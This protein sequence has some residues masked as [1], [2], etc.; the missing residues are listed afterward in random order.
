MLFLLEGMHGKFRQTNSECLKEL[1]PGWPSSNSLLHYPK[2]HYYVN[3]SSKARGNQPQKSFAC[4]EAASAD[5]EHVEDKP[6]VSLSELFHG[7]H[8]FR[9]P[10]KDLFTTDLATPKFATSI[11]NMM[12]NETRTAED[13]LRLVKEKLKELGVERKENDHNLTSWRNS[14]TYVEKSGHGSTTTYSGKPPATDNENEAITNPLKHYIFGSEVG[15]PETTKVKDHRTSLWEL[16]QKTTKAE[17]K[18]E[19]KSNI[20]EQKEKRTDKSP[21]HLMKKILKRRIF[22]P[23]S[24][25][26]TA[27][28]VGTVDSASADEKLHKI[29]RML[30]RVY[31]EA[32]AI[33]Q[34]S[35]NMWKYVTKSNFTNLERSD[36]GIVEAKNVVWMDA[37]LG[38][39]VH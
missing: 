18:T 12:Q 32:S 14:F 28:S 33:S 9:P 26:S 39:K 23:S 34:K 30:H 37:A 24:Q 19:P 17:K 29:L 1:A 6:S 10:G 3:S 21:V 35:Q 15:L 22:H 13:E 25:C 27:A 8:M 7:F 38:L 5:G 2:S 11:E 36:I 16:F 4:L 20:G 31:P